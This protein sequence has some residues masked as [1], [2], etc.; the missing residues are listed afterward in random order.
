MAS[1]IELKKRMRKLMMLIVCLFFVCMCTQAQDKKYVYEDTAYITAPDEQLVEEPISEKIEQVEEKIYAIET[2]EKID[3]AL[4]YNVFATPADSVLAW[5]NEK[6]F[7]Y[8]KNLDSLLRAEKNKK[9][10]EEKKTFNPPNYNTSWLQNLI[11][12][13]ILQ[14]LFWILAIFFVLF[15][16]YKLFLTKGVFKRKAK[17]EK[18]NLPLV[19]EEVIDVHTNFDNLITEALKANN[20]RLAVRY[21]YLKS[22]HL[23]SQKNIITLA[24]DKTNYQYVTEI[25]NLNTKRMFASLL[26]NYEYVWYGEFNIDGNTY[27][28]FNQQFIQFNQTI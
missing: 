4:Y 10:K 23:L 28:T 14:L 7:S 19:E 6:S 24:V 22:L 12:G 13:L 20:Y 25:N 1:S 18:N 16:L 8:T 5:K 9:E 17:N 15:V 21:Q 2:T 27:Q 26:L 11:N 3:T